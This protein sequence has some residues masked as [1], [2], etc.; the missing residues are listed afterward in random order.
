MPNTNTPSKT[1]EVILE[2]L[3][4]QLKQQNPKT[5][6]D[7]EEI[8]RASFGAA[9]EELETK[10]E[11]RSLYKKLNLLVHPDRFNPDSHLKNPAYAKYK[12]LY[13][14]LLAI[15]ADAINLPT[16]VLSNFRDVDFKDLLNPS[17]FVGTAKKV[18]ESFL[19][20]W[21]DKFI[22]L[23]AL[24]YPTFVI[25]C[26]V[27]MAV[28]LAVALIIGLIVTVI[29]VSILKIPI[30]IATTI[31]Q[32]ITD[33]FTGF[34]YSKL[35]NE[36]PAKNSEEFKAARSSFLDEQEGFEE[37]KT[38]GDEEFLAF[39]INDKYHT[40][41]YSN[42][43]WT[44]QERETAFNNIAEEFDNEIYARI[45]PGFLGNLLMV[46]KAF[47]NV[48]FSPLPKDVFSL[49]ISLLIIRPIQLACALPLS[50]LNAGAVV[51]SYVPS[52]V[53]VASAAALVIATL[54]PFIIINSPLLVAAFFISCLTY[55]SNVDEEQDNDSNAANTSADSKHKQQENKKQPQDVK[56]HDSL[57]SSTNEKKDK[58]A[59][60]LGLGF[61]NP[62]DPDDLDDGFSFN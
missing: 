10:E 59:P 17:N 50:L 21:V 35:Y 42:L 30:S 56:H 25:Y 52:I 32:Y 38:W 8:I 27:G 19:E 34:E 6:T 29:A 37:E 22:E 61:V 28:V 53:F 7:A 57:F 24:I 12:P 23:A 43:H 62:D 26:M 48:L 60:I 14:V 47:Y 58:N 15:D 36:K 31:L 51:L 3:L 18:Y 16:K 45:T 54:T 2:E 20:K 4:N 41:L 33:L 55:E 5:K 39:L 49:L 46:P 11:R 40:Q 13:D 9:F 1:P 44:R